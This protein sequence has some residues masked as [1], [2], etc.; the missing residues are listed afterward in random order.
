MCAEAGVYFMGRDTSHGE[1][2]F[3]P[4]ASNTKEIAIY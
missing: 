1:L 4:K 2:S 3:S